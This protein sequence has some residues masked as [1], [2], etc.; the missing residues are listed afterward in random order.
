MYGIS[1]G[2]RSRPIDTGLILM[3]LIVSGGPIHRDRHVLTLGSQVNIVCE[4]KQLSLEN[5]SR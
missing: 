3:Y 1:L 4:E 2:H 5:P